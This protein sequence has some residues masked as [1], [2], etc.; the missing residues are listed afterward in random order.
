M[1]FILNQSP[2]VPHI[3]HG[4]FITIH[5]NPTDSFPIHLVFGIYA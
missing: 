1:I 2:H 5:L 3:P 4:V